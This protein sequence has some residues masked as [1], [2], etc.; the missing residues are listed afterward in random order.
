MGHRS[1][2]K[3]KS[4]LQILTFPVWLYHVRLLFSIDNEHTNRYHIAG[5]IYY[6]CS[7]L[8]VCNNQIPVNITRVANKKVQKTS[9]PYSKG[10]YSPQRPCSNTSSSS[11]IKYFP[12]E[13][14]QKITLLCLFVLH[15][16]Y[17][18]FL[19]KMSRT[20]FSPTK[21]MEL[22]G[23]KIPTH[24]WEHDT[25]SKY[26]RLIRLFP[27]SYSLSWVQSTLLSKCLRNFAVT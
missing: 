12:T 15:N 27:L 14:I 13:K 16:I 9:V 1:D 6:S 11:F 10:F 18:L 23:Q 22:N 2:R 5:Q 24:Q 20:L 25:Q 8:R 3:K 21:Q 17:N 7:A 4:S 19:C 26:P